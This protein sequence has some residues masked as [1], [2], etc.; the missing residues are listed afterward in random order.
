MI[1]FLLLALTNLCLL[2]M[3]KAIS[4]SEAKH[5]KYAKKVLARDYQVGH[6]SKV[7]PGVS[8]SET[9]LRAPFL[10]GD[11]FQARI[12]D[13]VRIPFGKRIVVSFAKP[14]KTD[15]LF[16]V[17]EAGKKTMETSLGKIGGPDAYRVAIAGKL[18]RSLSG[19]REPKGLA[20]FKAPQSFKSL[21]IT[22]RE[23]KKTTFNGRK[24]SGADIVSVF[25]SKTPLND[26]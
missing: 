21:T 20:C 5:L 15:A 19:V 16:C 8:Y 12:D 24:S 26:D 4:A 22:G 6:L 3:P 17:V 18:V 10:K 9:S 23:R 14:V 1:R 11:H 2:T 13:A 25:A 7:S